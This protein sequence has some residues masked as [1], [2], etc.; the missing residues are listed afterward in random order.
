M[1]KNLKPLN[2]VQLNKARSKEMNKDLKGLKKSENC[3]V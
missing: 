3:V 1:N 2:E